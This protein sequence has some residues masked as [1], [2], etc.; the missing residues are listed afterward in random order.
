MSNKH[1]IRSH[2]VETVIERVPDGV[3]PAEFFRQQID[4]CPL[5]QEARARG[6]E[7]QVHAGTGWPTASD[8]N[9]YS[10]TTRPIDQPSRRRP[11]FAKRPRW[12][13]MK[14]QG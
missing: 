9:I 13:T 7:P 11:L 12:R 10:M 3:D 1:V 14:R 8:G 2:G 5:C 6:E 4:N